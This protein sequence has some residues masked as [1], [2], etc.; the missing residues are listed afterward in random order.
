MTIQL[1]YH[2]PLNQLSGGFLCTAKEHGAIVK[3]NISWT[4][5]SFDQACRAQ[6][7]RKTQVVLKD[8]LDSTP[9]HNSQACFMGVTSHG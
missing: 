9:E 1:R 5:L 4:A 7:K 3:G 2:A 8:S 6:Q